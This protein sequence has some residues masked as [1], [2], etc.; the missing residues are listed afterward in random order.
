MDNGSGKRQK[1]P[2]RKEARTHHLKNEKGR[3]PYSLRSLPV[4]LQSHRH[5]DHNGKLPEKRHQH[6]HHQRSISPAQIRRKNIRPPQRKLPQASDTSPQPLQ[7]SKN[8]ANGA[9][10]CT[11]YRHFKVSKDTWYK[12][13]RYIEDLPYFPPDGMSE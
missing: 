8:T 13:L 11:I 4:K 5:N 10:A 9:H 2:Q 1:I 6:L 12:Y 3:H 7:N